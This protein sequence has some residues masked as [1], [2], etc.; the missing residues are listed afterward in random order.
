MTTPVDIVIPAYRG[1]EATRRCLRSVLSAPVR[2]AREV[3]VIDDASPDPALSAYLREV[4]AQGQIR[5]IA[6][7]QNRGFVA[8]VNEGMRLH[9]DRDVVLL[10]S[11]T[12][13]AGDWLDRLAACAAREPLAGTLT[14]FSNNATICSYPRICEINRLPDGHTTTTLDRR[15]A[16][17][18]AGRS[19]EIPTAVGFCMF[20][21]RACLGKVGFFDEAAFGR[22]YGEEV[23][24]CMK[25]RRAGF[26]NLLCADVFV[27]H[28][29]E[30]SF[31]PGAPGLR[32]AAQ[33]IIDTRYPEFRAL[34]QDFIRDDP[35]RPFR[36]AAD[37]LPRPGLF[38]RLRLALEA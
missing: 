5:L 6:H 37:R 20:I 19:V 32:E 16:Q 34:V 11:D 36:E 1:V 12:Q 25:A 8:S 30:V 2:I 22:G 31:G 23:D 27:Y 15:F 13:V 4:E 14:P 33:K 29:G 3:I 28:E 35:P 21:G 9:A 24:F 18:N 10:N 17:A 38:E 26:R 7:A